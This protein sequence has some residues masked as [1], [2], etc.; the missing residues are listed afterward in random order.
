M[1]NVSWLQQ[2]RTRGFVLCTAAYLAALIAA[3]FA[4]SLMGG[5]SPMTIAFAGII[6]STL[7]IYGFARFTGNASMFD[8]YWSLGPLAVAVYFW[9]VSSGQGAVPLR[10]FMVILLVG[11]WSIR[12][13][14]NWAGTWQGLGHED[15][16][17]QGLRHKSGRWF[18]LVELAGIELMPA[19]VI[20]AGCLSLYPALV[21]GTAGFGFLDVVAAGITGGAIAVEAVADRQLRAFTTEG[22][23]EVMEKGLWAYSRHPNYFGEVMFWWGLFVFALAAGLSYWW[24]VIGPVAVTVLF[25]T[26][27][28]PLMEQRNLKRRPGYAEYQQRT[29]VFFPWFRKS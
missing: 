16:R 26:I 25:L 21:T 8:P 1:E 24:T 6:A 14:L 15:W 10:Q 13:T 27:S 7:V 2:E 29:Q 11:I 18:W 5:S 28:I 23:G 3:V 9:M 20:F 12:L 4:G 19:L 22:T 17:Y